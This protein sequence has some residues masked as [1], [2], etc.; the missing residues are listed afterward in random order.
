MIKQ[1]TIWLL[2]QLTLVSYMRAGADNMRFF[3]HSVGSKWIYEHRSTSGHVDRWTQEICKDSI[4]LS[5]NDSLLLLFEGC[6]SHVDPVHFATIDV[7]RGFVYCFDE[8]KYKLNSSV[9]DSWYT[10][11]NN[12]DTIRV[13][14]FEWEGTLLF[15]GKERQTRMYSA[16]DISGGATELDGTKFVLAEDLGLVWTISETSTVPLEVL[17]GYSDGTVTVGDTS[18][19]IADVSDNLSHK[20]AQFFPNP[21]SLVTVLSL[22]E[23]VEVVNIF[24][25]DLFGRQRLATDELKV[26]VSCLEPGLYSAQIQTTKESYYTLLQVV[27]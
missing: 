24:V 9:G 2:I 27:R 20:A 17:V 26:E 25:Y 21:A 5:N 6:T 19:R 22:P 16:H 10:L 1:T 13:F 8:L 23:D 7:K 14:R 4:S 18:T 12:G 15:L 3:P 11:G